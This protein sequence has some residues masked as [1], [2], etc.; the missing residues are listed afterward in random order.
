MV[1]VPTSK[2]CDNC[3][4]RKKKCG[5]QRPSCAECTRSGLDCPGYP[6][7]WKFI[8]E[9]AR[10]A[11][12]Y[13]HVRF[14]NDYD[15]TEAD[16]INSH[17]VVVNSVESSSDLFVLENFE[18][19][20]LGIPRFHG[21]NPLATTFVYCLGCKVKGDLVP[22]WLMGSF[23]QYVPGR[24]GHNNALDDAISCIC[25]LYCD[26]SLKEYT[27]SKVIYRNYVRA[28]SSLQKCLADKSLCMQS[29]T[30][31]ASILLQVCELV[32][33]ADKG[34]WG[35]LARGTAQL[36]QTRG[37]DR[38]TDPFDL[39]MLES[40][41]SYIV[42][43]SAKSEEECYLRQ[44]KWRALLTT[45]STWPS[46]TITTRELRSLK[47]RIELCHQL[48]EL[49]S[50]LMEVSSFHTRFS[51]LLSNF[52][53]ILMDKALKMSSNMKVWLRCEVEPHI[54]STYLG[55]T[56]A[57][58]EYPDM[59]AAVVDCVANTT[60]LTLDK[61]ICLL[62]HRSITA[63]AVDTFDSPESVESC[64]RR[65][66]K[67]FEYVRSEST[68]AAR[69]LGIGLRQFQFSDPKPLPTTKT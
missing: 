51:G 37:V 36:I 18:N 41:L 62:H 58:I 56:T 13:S 6:A 49:P 67:A 54:F 64:Y 2:R 33:N 60:L 50:I 63:H 48:F 28:L 26:R 17:D 69:P 1:G 52:D 53:S 68:L 11:K 16:G 24:L 21:N 43:Q 30:L 35:N 7:R 39:G 4:K 55:S 44:P 3:R 66:L 31:C 46:N 12:Q 38:Y 8:D 23:F 10:L 47:L 34:K 22:M 25:S 57:H 40:Q 59:V 29:E 19:A 27:K 42:V 5:E 45:I 15:A 14:V 65:A 9:T 61:I 32:I 20:R